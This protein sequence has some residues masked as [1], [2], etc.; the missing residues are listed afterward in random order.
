MYRLNI[1]IRQSRPPEL[2]LREWNRLV[3]EALEEDVA[4]YWILNYLPLH[5][6]PGAVQRYSYAARQE[7]YNRKKRTRDVVKIKGKVVPL[8]KPTGPLVLTGELRTSLLGKTP[9]Q[10]NS[11]ATVTSKK[12]QLRI[13][14]RIPHPINPRNSGELSRYI[15]EEISRLQMIAIRG[16]NKRM[17]FLKKV[18]TIKIAA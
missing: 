18:K 11:K 13:P 7:K 9:E 4:P 2:L 1:K 8:A 6:E 3:R 15:H 5:F 10:F 17:A 14:L 12:W 16:I